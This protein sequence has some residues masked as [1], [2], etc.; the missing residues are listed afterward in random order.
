MNRDDRLARLIGILRDGRNHRAE[1]LAAL[2]GVTV[3]TLYRD[4]DRLRRAGVPLAGR[5]G[6]GYAASA[7]VTLPPLDLTMAEL[8][9]LHL[10]LA[11]VGEGGDEGLR[12]AAGRLSARI[13]ALLPEDRPGEAAVWGWSLAHFADGARAFALMP[14]IRTAIRARQKLRL[15][16]DDDA[17]ARVVRPLSLDYWGRLWTVT[18]WCETSDSLAEFRLDRIAELGVLPQLFVDEPG[19]SLGPRARGRAGHGDGGRDGPG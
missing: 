16:G 2:L 4:M 1:D 17:G 14:V 7:A 3:R 6:K 13:D 12:A 11:V 18:V 9:A 5:R 10:G 15:R 8:E 19:K